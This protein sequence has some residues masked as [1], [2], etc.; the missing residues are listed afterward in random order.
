M[1]IKAMWLLHS[2]GISSL[3]PELATGRQWRI[4]SVLH[5]LRDPINHAEKFFAD[6]DM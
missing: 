1:F 2:T 5:L 6:L 4:G 3:D